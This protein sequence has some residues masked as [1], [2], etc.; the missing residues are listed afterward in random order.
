MKG[1]HGLIIAIVLGGVGAIVNFLYLSNKGQVDNPVSFVVI[2]ARTSVKQGERITLKH[3]DQITI[4]LAHAGK[5]AKYAF[6]WGKRDEVIGFRSV[7]PY[8]GGELVFRD[9]LREPLP[10]LPLKEQNERAVYVPIDPSRFVPSHIIPLETRVSFSLPKKGRPNEIELVGPF[11]VLA[12]GNRFGHPG[13]MEK[14]KKAQT[15]QYV[16]TIL[17][18]ADANNQL[19]DKIRRLIQHI[20]KTKWQALDVVLHPKKTDRKKKD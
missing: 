12:V 20:R 7:R 17:G 14:E 2:K 19:D 13:T 8:G 16:L 15:H 6:T 3:I 9:D 5:L 10:E 11:V 4:P 18:T 1:I